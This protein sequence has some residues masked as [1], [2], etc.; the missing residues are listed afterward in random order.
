MQRH[1][2]VSRH[3]S[4]E[5]SH[6]LKLSQQ[7]RLSLL[8]AAVIVLALVTLA[9]AVIGPSSRSTVRRVIILT[10]LPT[11][12]PTAM[13]TPPAVAIPAEAV[14]ASPTLVL[15]STIISSPQAVP[16]PAT[17]AVPSLTPLP[18]PTFTAAGDQSGNGPI[19]TALV[20]LNVRAGPGL[21][22]PI[23]DKLAQGQ[24]AQ[25]SGKNSEGTWWQIVYPPGSSSLA[26]VSAEAQYSTVSTAEEVQ[27]AQLP[28]PPPPT[29]TSTSA[30]PAQPIQ[31][32]LSTVAS[33][34]QPTQTIVPTGAP[35]VGPTA[36]SIATAPGW[37]FASVRASTDQDEG[38]LL[39]YGDMI[40][41][42]GASQE[43]ALLTGTFYDTQGQVIADEDNTFD[44]WPIEIVPP[45]GR[46]PFELAVE[47]IPNAANF[48]LRVEAE[49]S[50]QM[51]RQD[52]NFLNVDQWDEEDV[53]CLTGELQNPEGQLQEYLLIVAILYDSQD[54][55]INFGDYYAANPGDIVGDQSLDFEV[56]IDSPAEDVARY[57]LRAWG[58]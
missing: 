30:P 22:Y 4:L 13:A 27:L 57:E 46:V 45:G 53:Y 42:T 25:V 47:G 49:A 5:T 41:D 29:A 21:D 32:P 8:L 48:N 37:A 6:Q 2:D 31:T 23:V 39:L 58:Q 43:V 33:A 20:G 26:W 28:S 38:I 1:K 52:F 44:Y 7:S 56:C 15:T 17:P 54:N 12:T 24:S 51:P 55:V 34:T 19:L 14:S 9:C 18:P 16:L 11:L 35:T 36:T 3:L 50:S 40:N 10:R